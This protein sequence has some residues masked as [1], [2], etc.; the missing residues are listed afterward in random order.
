[1]AG[2]QAIPEA[3]GILGPTGGGKSTLVMQMALGTSEWL[4]LDHH[5][6]GAP[7]KHVVVV[8]YEDDDQRLLAR[9]SASPPG[10]TRTCAWPW[11]APARTSPAAA[12]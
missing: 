7:L 12:G 9:A 6:Y 10:S 4:R 1:M 5:R 3:C 8:S 11:T 2:G